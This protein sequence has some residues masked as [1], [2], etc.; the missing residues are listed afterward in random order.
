MLAEAIVDAGHGVALGGQW[1]SRAALFAASP[2]GPAVNPNHD[3]QTALDFRRQIEIEAVPLV[4]ALD[5]GDVP[6]DPDALGQAF[7]RWLRPF[8]RGRQSR[9]SERR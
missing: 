9:P 5:V 3:R 1:H 2:P 8:L 7:R 6:E 4:T